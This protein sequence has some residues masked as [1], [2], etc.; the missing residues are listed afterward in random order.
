MFLGIH[1]FP[2]HAKASF[3]GRW[4]IFEWSGDMIDVFVLA[5]GAGEDWW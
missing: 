3:E 2:N 1:S 4:R 5:G